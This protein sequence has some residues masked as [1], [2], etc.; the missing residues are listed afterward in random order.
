VRL[1]ACSSSVSPSPRGLR[2]VWRRAGRQDGRG[3]R[4]GALPFP[5]APAPPS[6]AR[7]EPAAPPLLPRQTWPRRPPAALA[8]AAPSWRRH[9]PSVARPTGTAART[10]AGSTAAASC[11]T[12]SPGTGWCCRANQG[13]GRVGKEGEAAQG[14]PGRPAL[15]LDS[16]EGPSHVGLSI[17]GD[18]FV[19]APS[20][21][22]VVRVERVTDSYWARR[23]LERGARADRQ[24][25]GAVMR[26]GPA[27]GRVRWWRHGLT[28]RRRVLRRRRWRDVRVRH[29]ARRR[30]HRGDYRRRRDTAHARKDDPLPAQQPHRRTRRAVPPRVDDGAASQRRLLGRERGCRH[31]K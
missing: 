5:G 24:F 28:L 22:G 30:C 15:L 11:S 1:P 25:T 21:R 17:G 3:P 6:S 9:S 16:G 2:V 29:C 27:P 10:R 13:S 14:A 23:F 26:S 12:S 19:H 4:R 31:P 18:Q 8:T 7:P 20:E